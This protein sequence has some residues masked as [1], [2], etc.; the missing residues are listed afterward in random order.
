MKTRVFQFDRHGDFSELTLRDQ[1]LS[2]PG[3][4]QALLKLRAVGLNNSEARYVAGRYAPPPFFPTSL[5]MEAVGEIVALGAADPA[6]PAPAETPLKVGA[7]VAL[8]PSRTDVAGMGSY[9]EHGLYPQHAL[10]PVPEG[11]SDVE[12]AALWMGMLTAAGAFSAAGL[13]RHNAEGKTVLITAATSSVGI[14]ALKIARAWGATTIATTRS[15]RK[16]ALLE[17]HADRVVVVSEPGALADAIKSATGGKGFDVALDP[18]GAEYLGPMVAAAAP[19]AQI[20]FY[21]MMS[22]REAP[23][24]IPALMI[25]DLGI[26][27]FTLFRL[28]RTPGLVE[29][30]VTECLRLGTAVRPVVAQSFAFEDAPRA[31]AQLVKGE[32]VGKLVLTVP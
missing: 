12:G 4:G 9:R 23:L 30:I 15:A 24:S 26:H 19:L 11:F 3:P 13:S 31:L 6:R 27:G 10:A 14:V 17:A 21:E 20:V 25:K 16:A 7:R 1:E 5:G 22:G 32:H 2:E 8:I 29:S 18:A 28:L